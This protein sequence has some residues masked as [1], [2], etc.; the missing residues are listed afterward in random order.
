MKKTILIGSLLSVFILITIPH[1][2][3][4]EYQSRTQSVQSL[5]ESIPIYTDYDW[6]E[7]LLYSIIFNIMNRTYFFIDNTLNYIIENPFFIPMIQFLTGLIFLS[8]N[9]GFLLMEKTYNNVI[10]FIEYGNENFS[11]MTD[12]F[13]TLL[14]IPF[15]ILQAYLYLFIGT[16]FFGMPITI[17][18]M[19]TTGYEFP[20]IIRLFINIAWFFIDLIW[21]I[22]DLFDLPLSNSINSQLIYR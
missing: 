6:A 1:I 3:A 18:F 16:I 15:F 7:E 4:V 20:P 14:S 21:L 13:L 2:S 8:L 10:D 12:T 5:I 17:F 9:F 22:G 11:P 19:F